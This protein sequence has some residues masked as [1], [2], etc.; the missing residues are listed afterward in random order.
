MF[1]MES[2][3]IDLLVRRAGPSATAA[4]SRWATSVGRIIHDR[5]MVAKLL[6]ASPHLFL[7]SQILGPLH[8]R[9]ELAQ[10]GLLAIDE[11]QSIAL[12]A[13]HV[14]E[15]LV[16]PILIRARWIVELFPQ[17]DARVALAR[18][19][20]HSL[21]LVLLDHVTQPPR[22][23]VVQCEATLHHRGKSFL[24]T[25]LELRAVLGRHHAPAATRGRNSFPP[26]ATRTLRAQREWSGSEGS[27]QSGQHQ[28]AHCYSPDESERT[29]PISV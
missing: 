1:S 4:S 14:L 12:N 7:Q 19:Q 20:I 16:H 23:F 21:R 18:D 22:L 25:L 3:P 26:T 2:D 9:E 28:I 27:D 29:R 8:R 13:A 11:I 10:I 24:E 17:G 15:Q 6:D 5:R